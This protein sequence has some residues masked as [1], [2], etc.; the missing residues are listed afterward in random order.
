MKISP[1]RME[2][3]QSTWENRVELNLSES[4]VHPMTPRELFQLAEHDPDAVLDQRLFYNQSNGTEELREAIAGLYPGAAIDNVLVTNGGSEANYITSWSLLESSDVAVMQIPNYMQMWGHAE[5]FA[6]EVRPFPLR[7]ATLWGPD[8]EDLRAQVDKDVKVIIVTNPNNPTGAIL[9]ESEIDEI[10]RIAA[11]AEAWIIADEIYAGAEL[12]GTSAPSFWGR[13]DRLVVTAGLSKAYGLPGLRVGWAIGPADFIDR[14]WSYK[15]YTTIAPG[16]LSD[17]CARLALR[18]QT[19]KRVLERTRAILGEN[20]A[21]LSDWLAERADIF[22]FVPP[23]AGAICYTRYELEI[24]SGELAQRLKDEESVLVVPGD[25]F[26]MDRYLRIGFGV[27]RDEL[28][29]ALG[30]IEKVVRSLTR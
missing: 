13:Y 29:E 4:G 5:V 20:L 22:H 26:N 27:P 7:E 15:D 6:G 3:W 24:G 21:T 25:H 8:L 11:S 19:R 17:L 30:R 10:V 18:P 1:F 12:D 2:R 16:T 23:R 28:L 9:D 14:L